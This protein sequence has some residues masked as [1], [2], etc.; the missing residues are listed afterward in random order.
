[1]EEERFGG[2]GGNDSVSESAFPVSGPPRKFMKDSS[3]EL[4]LKV[5]CTL[6]KKSFEFQAAAGRRREKG[7]EKY[8]NFLSATRTFAFAVLRSFVRFSH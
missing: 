6:W 5:D 7:D 4:L 3:S 1:M 2:G 8:G